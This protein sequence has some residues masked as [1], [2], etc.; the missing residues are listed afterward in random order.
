MT[1]WNSFYS[2]S[3]KLFNAAFVTENNNSAHCV[4]AS[5][6]SDRTD[7]RI[8][9]ISPTPKAEDDS[10]TSHTVRIKIL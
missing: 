4:H 6:F 5:E 2:H 9:L 3:P 10:K 8:V 1:R 7:H